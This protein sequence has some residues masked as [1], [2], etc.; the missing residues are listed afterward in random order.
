VLS[1]T[2]QIQ[3]SNGETCCETLKTDDDWTLARSASGAVGRHAVRGRRAVHGNRTNHNRRPTNIHKGTRHDVTGSNCVTTAGCEL[4]SP[5]SLGQRKCRRRQRHVSYLA[6]VHGHSSS[7]EP[8]PVVVGVIAQ[9][10]SRCSL[11]IHIHT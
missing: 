6:G 4:L 10:S 1:P 3:H 9:L 5:K 7:Q 2:T 8:Q 11:Y